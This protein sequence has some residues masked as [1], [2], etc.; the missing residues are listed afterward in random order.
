[1]ALELCHA[2]TSEGGYLFKQE[3]H[4]WYFS[5][6]GNPWVNIS[7]KDSEHMLSESYAIYC[8]RVTSKKLH[9]GSEI[10]GLTREYISTNIKLDS[11]VD[12]L[13]KKGYF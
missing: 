1:M 3:D 9:N 12:R 7:N 5:C 10:N 4:K 2:F 6:N 13:R 11:I 8:I